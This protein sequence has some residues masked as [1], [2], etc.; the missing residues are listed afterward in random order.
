MALAGFDLGNFWDDTDCFTS[1]L[2][3]TDDL[4]S[5]AEAL[6]GY[7]L[8]QSY[9]TLLKSR[10]GGTPINDCFP[11]EEPTSWSG[12]HIAI[13][14]IRGIGGQWGIDSEELGSRFMV[15]KAGY[16]DIGIVVCECP[17]G[18]HDAVM[19]DYTLCGK[20]GE[21]RV[22]HVDVESERI[23]LLAPDFETFIRG[24]VNAEV[25]DTSEEDFKRDFAVID[26]GKFSALLA[27]LCLK[28]GL[29]GIKP[30]I[31]R[32]CKAILAEKGY[33]ALHADA[34]SY[35]VYDLQFLLFS[36]QN[37]VTGKGQYLKMYPAM[38]ALPTDGEF[39][40]GGYA[41]G[42]VEAWFE[43]RTQTG[44]IIS[45]SERLLLSPEYREELEK[46]CL[47]SDGRKGSA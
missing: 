31:R 46:K 30:A 5:R 19:L 42:F 8:P 32:I 23:T 38:L 11:T 35:L 15:E 14:G 43:D 17:S 36:T 24:L 26:T 9:V 7:K 29:P 47:R 13:A 37:A 16:P 6:L 25:Y 34:L 27:D 44:K 1:P 21:P 3:L 45:R 10:N 39:T 22:L 2:P 33:F 4:V 20:N 18:G 12:D 40:T 28:S 41:P